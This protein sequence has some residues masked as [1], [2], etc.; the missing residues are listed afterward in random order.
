MKMLSKPNAK[1]NA[2][3]VQSTAEK[4]E[5]EEFQLYELAASRLL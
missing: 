1:S 5:P 4:E 3:K 2:E